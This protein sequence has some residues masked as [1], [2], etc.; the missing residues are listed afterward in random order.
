M[1]TLQDSLWPFVTPPASLPDF[2][3]RLRLPSST[4]ASLFF[5]VP[6]SLASKTNN[7][8]V[9]ECKQPHIKHPPPRATYLEWRAVIPLGDR[10]VGSVQTERSALN[11]TPSHQRGLCYTCGDGHLIRFCCKCLFLATHEYNPYNIVDTKRKDSVFRESVGRKKNKKHWMFIPGAGEG[12]ASKPYPFT[13]GDSC[14]MS[15][16]P[17][18]PTFPCLNWRGRKPYIH[19]NLSNT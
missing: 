4:P 9:R 8:Y 15:S 6:E 5:L 7:K 11:L 19:Q 3:R 13:V 16:F 12:V 14:G 18:G 2:W 1:F 17:S 10:R